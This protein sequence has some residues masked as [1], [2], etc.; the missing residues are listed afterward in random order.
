LGVNLRVL[1]PKTEIEFNVLSGKIVAIDAYNSLYQFLS[2]IRQPDGTPLKDRSGKITSHLIGLLYRT[3]KL[4]EK[5][6][7][8][9]YVFDGESPELKEAEVKRRTK[10]KA[11]ALIKYETALKEGDMEI[12][13]RYAQ[14]TSKMKSYMPEDSKRLLN[15]LG[16]PWI[17]A[18]SEGEAQAAYMTQKGTADYCGSQDYDSLLFGATRLVRNLTVSGRRKIPRRNTYV[19]VFPEVMK[20][21]SVLKELEITRK[22]LIDLAILVGTDFNPGVKG[23]G[24]KTALKLIKKHGCLEEVIPNLKTADCIGDYKGI[25]DLF[26]NPKITDDYKLEWKSPNAKGVVDFLCRE[27]DFSEDRVRSAVNKMVVSFKE[28]K[29]KTTLESWFG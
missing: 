15:E 19:N 2:S 23:V 22:Q 24:P 20:L 16:I 8:V 26:L 9:V 4:V 27:R 1:I 13:R 14:M 10:V 11:E 3:A 28:S 6:V 25:R 21:D 7:K 29:S 17:Q 18:P 5:D 12:A